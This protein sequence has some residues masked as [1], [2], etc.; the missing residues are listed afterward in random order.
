M[1]HIAIDIGGRESQICVLSS[2]GELKLEKR[3]PT[4]KLKRFFAEIEPS[5]VILE[6]CAEAFAL[7]GQAKDAGHDVRI[8]PATLVR[9]LG[10]GQRGIKT[11]QRD[12]R[13]LAEASVRMELGSVHVPSQLSRELK[14]ASGMREGMVASRT[15]LINSVR[16]W[17][18]G[19]LLSLR[20][21]DT[22]VFAERI[23]EYCSANEIELPTYVA[24]QLNA[25]EQ[26]TAEIK[27]AE[28]ELSDLA[29]H[30]EECQLLMSIPGVGPLTAIRFLAGIDHVPRFPDAH[31]LESYFGLTPGESSSSDSKHR[32]S[33]TKAGSKRVRWLL[34]QA[35]WSAF[36]TR[37]NDPMVLWSKQIMKR[38]G[39]KIAIVALSRKLA[40]IMFAVLRDGTRYDPSRGSSVRDEE[41]DPTIIA[42]GSR[43]VAIAQA[44]AI[45]EELVDLPSD[46]RRLQTPISP[47]SPRDPGTHSPPREI[48]SK[49][50]LAS[51]KRPAKSPKASPQTLSQP[52]ALNG[53]ESPL[54][55]GLSSQRVTSTLQPTRL[56][57][58]AGPRA[59][60]PDP[61]E[62]TPPTAKLN[63]PRRPPRIG[64]PEGI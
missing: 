55:T 64:K 23:R 30:S 26:L 8:V 25:I 16:G 51:S 33:L 37:P 29:N 19:E 63:K 10:V 48:K 47:A 11:D 9:S 43:A 60:T 45:G 22:S 54:P 4:T 40:G 3:L 7:A 13:C 32:T 20:R 35:A 1:H 38:R 31:R 2:V 5:R 56:P 21:C 41:L 14:T 53:D 44:K 39:T 59:R 57:E 61:V 34:V 12:A 15:G 49:V 58:Q 18:R 42:T 6:T 46:I 27:R 17:L 36:R 52:E 24:R 50:R 28:A 62:H